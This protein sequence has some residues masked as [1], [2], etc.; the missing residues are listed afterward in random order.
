MRKPAIPP[1]ALPVS[2]KE[3]KR[4]MKVMLRAEGPTPAGRYYHWDKLRRLEPPEGLNHREWWW[5]LKSSRRP[6]FKS[7]P[8]QDAGGR[9]FQYT[10]PDPALELLHGLDKDAAGQILVTAQVAG[11]EVRDRYVINSLMEEA[12]TSSQIEG[13]AT[14]R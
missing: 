13:A 9:P 12:I 3:L 14:T 4:F 8:M 2:Q 11:A 5:L 10:L 7:L 1:A 6:M